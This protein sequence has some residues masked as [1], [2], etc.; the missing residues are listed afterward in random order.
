MPELIVCK[1]PQQFLK[2]KKIEKNL[3]ELFYFYVAFNVVFYFT[4]RSR[5]TI[6]FLNAFFLDL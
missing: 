1:E 5:T 2:K 4:I 6:V 3:P